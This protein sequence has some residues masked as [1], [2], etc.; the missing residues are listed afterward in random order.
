[1]APSYEQFKQ[2]Y[3]LTLPVKSKDR[4]F[5]YIPYN[6]WQSSFEKDMFIEV[7]KLDDF[8]KN[9]L[10]IYYNGERGLTGFVINCFA[11]NGSN[12]KP[13]GKY[14]PDFLM[15]KRKNQELHKILIIETKGK[16][17]ADQKAFQLRKKYVSSDFFKLNNDKFGYKRFDFLYLQ[18]SNG[19]I[20]NL[21]KIKEKIINFFND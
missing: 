17:F 18:D 1:M 10:D 2:P 13:I 4:T 12:W 5:H 20:P 7:L 15:V 9:E 21:T 8:T 3:E 19:V 14:T 11:K 16:D 6:F